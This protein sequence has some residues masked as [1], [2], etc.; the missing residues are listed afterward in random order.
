M[1]LIPSGRSLL[2][3]AVVGEDGATMVE[4]ALMIALIVLVAFAA[5]QVLGTSTSS[6]FADQ[7][8]DDA[9]GS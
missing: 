3:R 8:L 1:R 6:V 9:M 2:R 4:Y 7:T 5:V